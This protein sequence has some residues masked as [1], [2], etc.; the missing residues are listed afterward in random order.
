MLAELI[1]AN[2]RNAQSRFDDLRKDFEAKH[3]ENKTARHAIRGE[4]QAQ[5]DEIYLVRGRLTT[6]EDRLHQILGDNSGSGGLLN[7]IDKTVDELKEGFSSIKQTISDIPRMQ[8][9]VYGA[10]GVC[11]F[12]A[13]VIPIIVT[14]IIEYVRALHGR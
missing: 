8:R 12:L 2:D 5:K 6:V 7:K 14:I 3:L 10:I 11:A 1:A 9:L 13:F 4:V